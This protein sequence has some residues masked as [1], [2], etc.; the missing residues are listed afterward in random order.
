MTTFTDHDYQHVRTLGD[1][2]LATIPRR[3]AT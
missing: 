3:I 2:Y 1:D